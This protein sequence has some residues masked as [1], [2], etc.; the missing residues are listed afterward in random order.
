MKTAIV[1]GVAGQDGS[2]L[3][4][5]LIEKGYFVYGISRRKS[6][7]QNNPNIEGVLKNKNFNLIEGDLTDPTLMS[8]LIMDIKPHEFYN[9]GAQSHVGYSFKNPV[10]SF[11]TNAESVIMHLSLIQQ[12]SPYTRYYQ[13]STSEIL[14]GI[15]C[16]EKGYDEG[17]LPHPRS[18]YAVAKT[19]AHFAVKNYREAYGLYCC[20]GILF[21]HS[22]V[23]R[24]YDFATRKI[25]RNLARVKLGYQDKLKMGDLSAFR[26][27]GCSKDYVDA[28]WRMLNQDKFHKNKPNDY[29]V[30]TG[31]GATIEEMFRYVCEISGLIFEEVYELDERFIRPSDVPY[32]LG[33]SFK[34][35][36]E[37][38]WK[39]NY[40]WKKLLKEMY[41]YDYNKLINL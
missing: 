10:D 7:N 29:I 24:G 27:E 15:N 26:D 20:S 32:L 12:L 34:I 25:T 21:N 22:S 36:S 31:Q 9:L 13:A 1:T 35:R 23:R 14:G 11:R 37:L 39:P 38:G 19:A 40:D 18:P 8:R 28:M 33:N 30:S 16:P 5:F 3:S 2:Y 41:N 17:F 4:E 6:V